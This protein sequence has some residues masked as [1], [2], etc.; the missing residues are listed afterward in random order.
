MA[1]GH[2]A[3][4]EIDFRENDEV[5]ELLGNTRPD[6]IFHLAGTS[7]PAE[8]RRE[9]IA[10]H[11]NIT[12]PAV[13]LL[14]ALLNSHRGTRL[15]LVSHCHVYGRP[16][17]LP[18]PEDH[19]LAPTDTFGAARAAVEHVVKN[20]LPHG[21]DVVIARAF[22]HQGPGQRE[23]WA[24]DWLRGDP[25]GNLDLRRDLSDV[26]DIVE[27]YLL[28]AERGSSGQAYNLCAGEA[29]SLRTLHA[30]VCPGGEADRPVDPPPPGPP[31]VP[32]LWGDPSRA[33]ALGWKR[34]FPLEQ[35][36]RDFLAD[37]RGHVAG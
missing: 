1:A 18:I 8:M 34:R 20:Y 4:V 23:G 11:L 36:I 29:T 27:G 33:E 21:V 10:G 26:R 15:V 2:D 17:R 25:V 24:P 13:A 14:D 16:Q 5:Q 28:L 30:M 7:S 32:I 19:P 6:V 22:H 31:Q 9:P 12:K 3:D 37:F 35:T